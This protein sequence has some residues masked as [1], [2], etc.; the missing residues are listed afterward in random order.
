MGNLVLKMR[1][2]NDIVLTVTLEYF[3]ALSKHNGGTDE[4]RENAN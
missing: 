3:K 4:I 2:A 1:T